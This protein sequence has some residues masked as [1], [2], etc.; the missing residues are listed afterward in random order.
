MSGR[1]R[2]RGGRGGWGWGRGGGFNTFASQV[3]FDLFPEAVTLPDV[4]L[5]DIHDDTKKLL[6]WDSHL[7]N[8]W[9]ASPYFLEDKTSK[10][11]QS[12]HIAKFSDRKKNDFTRDS[13][14]QVLMFNDFPQELVQGASKRASRRKKFRWNPESE[15]KKLDFF[16]QQEKTNQIDTST[17]SSA[18]FII[19][20]IYCHCHCEHCRNLCHSTDAIIVVTTSANPVSI[21]STTVAINF[22]ITTSSIIALLLPPSPLLPLLQLSV[23]KLQGMGKEENDENEKKDGEDGDEDENAQEEDEEDI[24]DDDYNQ[25]IDFDDDEDDYNDVDDGDDEPTY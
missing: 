10:K 3:P 4:N 25:N 19:T 8:Y 12:M 14:S 20:T 11:R 6:R 15:M 16:E 9:E 21:A 18:A 22:I 2:G 1:G 5:D 13:L 7:Q 23:S 17:T 24:S